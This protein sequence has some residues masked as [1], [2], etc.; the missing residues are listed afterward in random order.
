MVNGLARALDML[1]DLQHSMDR[2]R[3][4]TWSGI[5]TTGG[6][7]FPSV[8]VFSEDDSVVLVAEMP[9]V[10]KGD[11]N[12][13]VRRNQIRISGTKQIDYGPEVSLH[14]RERRPGR[15]DRTFSVPFEIDSAGV[16]AH[17]R[18][19]LL[20]VRL[21]RAEADKARAIEVQ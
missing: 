20:A 8:N 16:E 18:Q 2:A 11:V 19:G 13:E 12:V 5:S 1:L 4:T 15:F 21:P 9:G 10:S 7:A 6:G 3:T 14:R 17:Q